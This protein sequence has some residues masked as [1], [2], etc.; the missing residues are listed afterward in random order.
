MEF[1]TNNMKIKII[2]IGGGGGNTIKRLSKKREQFGGYI[3]FYAANTDAMA[4]SSV[5]SEGKDVN[6]ILLGENS[7]KGNGAGGKPEIGKLAT[8]ESRKQIE[9]AIGDAQLLFIAAGM[10][11]GTGT[12]G[13]PIVAQIASER[14]ILTIGVVT[15]PFGYEGSERA[16]YAEEGIREMRKYVDVMVVASNQKAFDICGASAQMQTIFEKADDVLANSI[17]GITDIIFT[18]SLINVDFADV[19]TVLRGKKTAH[20][21]LG[22][23]TGENRMFKA[24]KMASTNLMLNTSIEGAKNVI[25]CIIADKEITG[26]AINKANSLIPKVVDKNAI[27]IHGVGFDN[28]LQ[29]E[30]KVIIIAS[31]LPGGDLENEE[32][33]EAEPEKEETDFELFNVKKEEKTEEPVEEEISEEEE[34]STVDNLLK[35]LQER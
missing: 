6:V 15:M 17:K 11:G 13:A 5:Q 10:G 8:E 33:Q 4:L 32:K 30:V 26:D 25:V 35:R 1:Q 18:H 20:I 28:N 14:Q 3:E 7:R 9:E 27:I 16:R 29:Q 22:H 19:T 34:D 12:G 2:G 21:G 23:A 31:G 24:L